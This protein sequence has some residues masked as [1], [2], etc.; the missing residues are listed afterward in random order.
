M[1]TREFYA[2]A[3]TLA[4][5]RPDVASGTVGEHR[6][7][8]RTVKAISDALVPLIENSDRRRFRDTAE[9]LRDVNNVPIGTAVQHVELTDE[10]E[11]PEC[12]CEDCVRGRED[13]DV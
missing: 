5:V 11:S 9:G 4:T 10:E 1:T 13:P 8:Y 6:F 7:W 12:N 3:K 2:L